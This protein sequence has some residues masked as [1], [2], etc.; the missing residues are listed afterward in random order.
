MATFENPRFCGLEE[1]TRNINNR[2]TPDNVSNDTDYIF[3]AAL[4]A[5]VVV[6]EAVITTLK[7]RS[8]PKKI[9]ES[10]VW[11]I[12]FSTMDMDMNPDPSA[13]ALYFNTNGMLRITEEFHREDPYITEGYLRNYSDGID[14]GLSTL[15][16]SKALEAV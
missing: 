13:D 11:I 10:G 2:V 3:M 12:R 5:G 8:I 9:H 16:A 7:S 15:L 4:R 1:Y 6:G 14:G